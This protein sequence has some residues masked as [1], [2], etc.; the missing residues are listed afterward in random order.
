ML[1]SYERL[2]NVL[3]PRYKTFFTHLGRING[4]VKFIVDMRADIIVSLLHLIIDQSLY[5]CVAPTSIWCQVLVNTFTNL[6]LFFQVG[7]HTGKRRK[8]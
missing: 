7:N 4:G 5:F 3:R 1:A 6:H 8:R 2:R